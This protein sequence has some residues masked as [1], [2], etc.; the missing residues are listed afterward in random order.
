[1]KRIPLLASFLCAA[2]CSLSS[3]TS[4]EGPRLTRADISE[5]QAGPNRTHVVTATLAFEQ[6]SSRVC[7]AYVKVEALKLRVEY[8]IDESAHDAVVAI[9]L[10]AAVTGTYDVVAGVTAC[11]GAGT[12]E[13]RAVAVQ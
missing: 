3:T 7:T 6:G 4:V 2:G 13:G 11:D 10:P 9:A 12:G 1:M 5:A 8:T